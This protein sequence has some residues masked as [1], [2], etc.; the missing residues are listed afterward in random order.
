MTTPDSEPIEV[1]VALAERYA[2]FYPE[3][4]RVARAR[5]H[6]SGG[7]TGLDTTALVHE[8]FL[9][10]SERA[11]L[12]G[13]SRGE[14]FAYVGQVLRSVVID[15]VRSATRDKRGGGRVQVTLTTA[16][17]LPSAPDQAVD[18]VALDQA[19]RRMQ[20]IDRNLYELFEAQVF[21]GLSIAELAR[22]REVTPRTIDRELLKARALLAEVLA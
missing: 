9:R 14:F 6:A 2:E 21:G 8:G 18:L 20:A 13:G 22:L 7:V 11:A 3:I 16:L 10:L 1:D 19:L 15:H 12:R 5:L 17:D 4:K